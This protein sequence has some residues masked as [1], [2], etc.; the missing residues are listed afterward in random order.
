VIA[1]A[2]A[3][4]GAIASAPAHA[5]A[6][7]RCSTAAKDRTLCGSVTVPLDRSG[8][9]PGTIALR[10]RAVP[11]AHGT[12]TGAPI[13]AL[14][15]GP[16]QAAVP[17]LEAFEQV[18]DPVLATRELIVFD[19]RGTGGS[20]SLRCAAFGRIGSIASTVGKCASELGPARAHY[21]TAD[22]VADI[23]ALRAA[24]GVDRLVVYGTSYG[25]KVALSYA[26]V[27]PEHVERLLL[28][29][30]VLPEGIDPFQRTTVAS[31]PRVLKTICARDCRFTRNAGADAAALTRR[32]SRAPLHGS[33]VGV[34]G[35]RFP[36]AIREED[37]LLLFLGGDVDSSLRAALPSAIRSAVMGD[38]APMLR[39]YVQNAL[40]SSAAAAGDSDALSLATTCE[41]GGVAWPAGTPLAQRGALVAAAAAAIPESAFAP[42]DRAT[43]RALGNA[44]LCR[45]WPESPIPQ[46]LPPLPT[47]PTL[48]FSGDEDL[49]TP[50][51]DAV[52]LA[53][54]LSG[55]QLLEV[56][57]AGHGAL[58]QDSTPCARRAL[59]AFLAGQAI[60]GCR[61]GRSLMPPLEL[62]PRRLADLRT[63][64]GLPARTG[65]TVRAVARTLKDLEAQA[66]AGSGEF[67][68]GVRFGGLRA[69]SAEIGES[70]IRMRGYS[71][72]PGVTLSG[73]IARKRIHRFSLQVG[74]RAA[75]RGTLTASPRGLTGVLDGRR[76]HV[77]PRVLRQRAAS[78]ADPRRAPIPLPV[79]PVLR[80]NR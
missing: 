49:R 22:S 8:G 17:L 61:P 65:R 71:Y 77:G 75:A 15:G 42:F 56:P 24:L 57:N 54:R 79:E 60:R 69:G 2:M 62:A 20:G 47:T 72:V 33:V 28:D 3:I 29:S 43:I 45:A 48:I 51:A 64:A 35:H 9:L 80:A 63:I 21:A 27:H 30:V 14:A 38:A 23:E 34:S 26:A 6:L 73:T 16:G 40:A 52:T 44:D 25:T 39:V 67:E 10:V 58:F 41:D 1:A 59:V 50:R 55:A 5:A 76:V 53:A 78:A 4:A 32:L 7:T 70:G 46:P 12:A 18:L 13:L 11:P 36:A 68:Q 19:Q 31:I 74:G 66:F 37:L